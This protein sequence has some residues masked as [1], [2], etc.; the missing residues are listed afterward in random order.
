MLASGR[1]DGDD[2]EKGDSAVSERRLW[3]TGLGIANVMAHP[4]LGSERDRRLMLARFLDDR[5]KNRRNRA[6]TN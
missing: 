5:M 6:R 1:K 4:A 2:A 3:T